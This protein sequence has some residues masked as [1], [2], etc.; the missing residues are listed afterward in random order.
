MFKGRSFVALAVLLAF[1]FVLVGCGGGGEQADTSM[2]TSTEPAA[3]GT[4]TATVNFEGEAPE[5][6]TYDA[7]GNSECGVDTIKGKSVVVNDNGT[8]KNVV[9]A[10]KSGPDG[11]D[12][13]PGDVQFT[14]KN[15]QYQPHVVTAK[16]GQKVKVGDK[17]SGLH[18]VRGTQDGNQLFNLQTFKGQSKEFS[19][20]NTGVVSLECD[21][22]P[23]MQAYL[24]VTDNG[25]AGVTGENGEVTLEELPE[26]DYTLEIWHEEYGTQ[27]KDVTISE[28]E[29]SSVSVTFSA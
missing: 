5:P 27:T 12:K 25:A 8:L 14:Q 17:D 9:V 18:N 7:S 13:S 15:C 10:V 21:V 22:H 28:D 23:W 11:L 4:L 3:T 26:G 24:Y 29:E 2:E 6:E 16:V 1:G 20:D 19:V